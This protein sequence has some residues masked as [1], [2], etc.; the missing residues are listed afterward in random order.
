MSKKL[1]LVLAAC[2]LTVLAA[3]CSLSPSPAGTALTVMVYLDADNNLDSYG[4]DDFNEMEAGFASLTNANVIV[5]FDRAS[6]GEWSDTRLYRVKSDD[7]P[8]KIAST[9]LAGMG[10]SSSGDKDELDMG[11]PDTLTAFVTYCETTYPADKTVL[12]IWDHGDGWRSSDTKEVSPL[13]KGACADDTSGSYL[14]LDDIGNALSGHKMNVIAFDACL[15][16]MVEVADEFKDNADYL[17]ASSEPIPGNGYDYTQWFRKLAGTDYSGLAIGKAA[18]DSYGEYYQG[19][20]GTTLSAYDLSKVDN[21]VAAIDTYAACFLNTSL[22]WIAAAKLDLYTRMTNSGMVY[23]YEDGYY[24]VDIYNLAAAVTNTYDTAG[25]IAASAALKAAV[26][27]LVAYSY[28]YYGTGTSY[29]SDALAH[30]IAIFINSGYGS[31]DYYNE[32]YYYSDYYPKHG[33]NV[34]NCESKWTNVV[35]NFVN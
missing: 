28:H 1:G 19:Y 20:E 9:R 6:Y 35:N 2:A 13:F 12:V 26:T 8:N 10:L 29:G 31:D 3:G 15:M 16:G 21:L 22:Q 7:D 4:L 23:G 11:D 32:G 25:S 33:L 5:L 18:V 17:V 30:G 27:N 34:F 14:Y 24:D